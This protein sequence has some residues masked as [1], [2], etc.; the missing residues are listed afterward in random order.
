MGG[1]W[2]ALPVPFWSMV[3]GSAALAALPG[4]SGFFSKDIILLTS[5]DYT[6]GAWFW[7]VAALAAFV[8]ALYSTRLI[9]VVFLGT[10]KTEPRDESGLNMWGPLV[11]LG[12]LAIGGGWFGL[13]PVA[14]V[15]PDAG[16]EG[17][18]EHTGALVWI[19]LLIPLLGVLTGYLIFGGAIGGGQL[20]VDG[21]LDTPIARGLRRWWF[22]GWGFDAFYDRL[23][24]RPFVGLAQLNKSDVVDLLIKGIVALASALNRLLA[25]TQTGNLRWYAM[26]MAFGLAVIMLY[27]VEVL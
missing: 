17:G 18:A 25:R 12:L 24:V 1:L 2:R 11:I 14:E 3:A 4:T 16:L 21:L 22:D 13:A 8:T 19:T 27:V 6:N 23:L 20:K 5:W 15:L 26:S 9:C 7:G 10:Q